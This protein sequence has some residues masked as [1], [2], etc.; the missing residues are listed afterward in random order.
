MI[1]LAQAAART[2]VARSTILRAIKRG[3]L[4]GIR[5]EAGKTW[6]V[7]PAELARVFP[8]TAPPARQN[9]MEVVVAQLAIA[10][11]RIAELKRALEDMRNDRND[12][13]NQ[14][15]LLLATLRETRGL[16]QPPPVGGK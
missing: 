10:E 11:E 13:K 5:G 4:S 14:A 1:T 6:L 15:S 7:D 16:E 8:V 12:W 3:T 9:A 2:G